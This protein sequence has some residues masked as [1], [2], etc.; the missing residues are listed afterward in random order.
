MEN[1]LIGIL[2]IFKMAFIFVGMLALTVTENKINFML[3]VLYIAS[4]SYFIESGIQKK[5]LKSKA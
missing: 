5:Y 3:S 2:H 4:T 1:Q